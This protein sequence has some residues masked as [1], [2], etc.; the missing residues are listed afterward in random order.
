MRWLDAKHSNM[1]VLEEKPV[2]LKIQDEVQRY[3]A[4]TEACSSH[5]WHQPD[6]MLGPLTR[7]FSAQPGMETCCL[8]TAAF[9]LQ[10]LSIERGGSPPP[11]GPVGAT[12]A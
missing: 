10:C 5:L 1:V 7:L 9:L 11:L 6:R 2:M 3:R 4:G 8:G 12:R